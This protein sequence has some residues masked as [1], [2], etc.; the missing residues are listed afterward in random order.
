MNSYVATLPSKASARRWEAA[1][2]LS[3]APVAGR[4]ALTCSQSQ[5]P[6][7]V[8]HLFYP[9]TCAGVQPAECCLLHPP[10]G[11]VSGD[12]LR[13]NLEAQAGAR[14]II[15]SPSA[16]KFYRSDGTSPQC[17]EVMLKLQAAQMAY[18]PQETLFYRGAQAQQKLTVQVDAHS[19]FLSAEIFM[20]GR[21]G[22]GECFDEGWVD[23]TTTIC[24]EGQALLHE[25]LRVNDEPFLRCSLPGLN[26][27]ALGLNLYLLLPSSAPHSTCLEHISESLKTCCER[28][29]NH[30]K[31]IAGVSVRLGLLCL[32]ALSNHI[33]ALQDLELSCLQ[34]I[35][36]A[37]MGRPFTQPRIWQT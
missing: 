13:F 27:Q 11:L 32:R 7:R 2:D 21:I 3:F 33:S 25:R 12:K 24:R 29:N 34:Q 36:P 15:T 9:E 18:L 14:V 26:G 6:L 4:T 31:L 28:A 30:G 19:T 35:F 5:G 23:L 20:L 8:L 22:C 17:Q 37:C 10:G 16:T 1:L